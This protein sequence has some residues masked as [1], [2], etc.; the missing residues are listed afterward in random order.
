MHPSF[1]SFIKA[2]TVASL[3]A[4]FLA[5][6]DDSSVNAPESISANS[7]EVNKPAVAGV[8]KGVQAVPSTR[9]VDKTVDELE[10]AIKV[11]QTGTVVARIDHQENAKSVDVEIPPTVLIM[12]SAPTLEV[13]LLQKNQQVA[14]DL[15]LKMLAYEDPQGSVKVAFNGVDYLRERHGLGEMEILTQLRDRLESV[16]E[17][18]S[19]SEVGPYKG[20]T[21]DTEEGEGVVVLAS[22]NDFPT[23]YQKLKQAI[24]SQGAMKMAAEIDFEDMAARADM[25]L[26]PTRLMVFGNPEV[27]SPMINARQSAALDLP[28]KMLV[29]QNEEG[30]VF[31][32]YN[33]PEF[34]ARRHEM[35]EPG[36]QLHSE[37]VQALASVLAGLANTAVIGGGE[38]AQ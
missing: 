3:L 37:P 4:A 36:K 8:P 7:P 34:I 13:P 24:E 38:L 11:G 26:R 30:Q 27:G 29:Y 19:G 6:C 9:T 2:G 10:Q 33:D 25:A 1:R 16:A 17:S 14:L 5:G 22:T 21:K 15:P 35:L 12:M 32:A 18:A 28:Q 31:V 23:T 20:G